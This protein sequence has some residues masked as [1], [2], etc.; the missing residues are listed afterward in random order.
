MNTDSRSW[1][2]QQPGPKCGSRRSI[3]PPGPVLPEVLALPL[4]HSSS[5]WARRR[6]AARRSGGQ[7]SIAVPGSDCRAVRFS[8]RV[9]SVP[10]RPFPV[11]DGRS[12]TRSIHQQ[13]VIP[14]SSDQVYAVLADAEAL[15]ALSGMSG[16]AGRAEGAE[17]SAFDG[18]VTGRHIELMP[19]QRIV[20]ACGS[21]R[22]SRGGTRSS[23]SVWS[24]RTAVPAWSSI[25]TAS[26]RAKTPLAATQPGTITWIPTGR[27]FTRRH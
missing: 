27:C 15:S 2:H 17:F 19:G 26:R 21:R 8:G 25:S 4:G 10:V 24:R 1:R 14:A 13:A 12:P 9:V 18:H 20:Q 7:V 6:R 3:R 22:G 23:G 16:Q 5:E 11:L